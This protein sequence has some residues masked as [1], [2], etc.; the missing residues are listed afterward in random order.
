LDD[1]LEQRASLLAVEVSGGEQYKARMGALL[2]C[3]EDGH[4]RPLAARFA[5]CLGVLFSPNFER[6]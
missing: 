3:G 5:F 6:F 4:L 1:A 2:G